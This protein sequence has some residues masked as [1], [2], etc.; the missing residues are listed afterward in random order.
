MSGGHNHYTGCSCPWCLHISFK[1]KSASPINFKSSTVASF[2]NPNARCPECDAPV[3]YYRSPFNGRVF[4]D[5]LGKPW[6]KHPCTDNDRPVRRYESSDPNQI[7]F[8]YAKT[9]K[10][11][12][13]KPISFFLFGNPNTNGVRRLIVRELLSNTSRHFE[14]SG[15]PDEVE[16]DPV[17]LRQAVGGEWE[18]DTPRGTFPVKLAQ[19]NPNALWRKR[20]TSAKTSDEN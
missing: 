8:D 5:N 14:A 9:W 15:I 10:E 19:L 16:H 20:R 1:D 17:F 3:F 7:D 13:W 6:P 2:T 18:L 12:G 11:G 4:F